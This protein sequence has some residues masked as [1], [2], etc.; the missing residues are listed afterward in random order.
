MVLD[1]MKIQSNCLQK[2]SGD[3]NKEQVLSEAKGCSRNCAP[4]GRP[5]R[6]TD[7]KVKD[8]FRMC[9][10]QNGSGSSTAGVWAVEHWGF[11]GRPL[12]WGGVDEK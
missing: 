5:I 6:W 10:S 7:S 11:L 9:Q 1:E 12:G 3:D 4:C 2:H 8:G